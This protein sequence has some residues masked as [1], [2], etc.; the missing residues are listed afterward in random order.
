MDE[1]VINKY[2]KAGEISKKVK[3]LAREIIKPNV[4]ALDVAEK[5]ESEIIRLGGKP[6]WP[7]NLSINEIAAHWTPKINDETVFQKGDLVKVDVGVHVDGF[8][9]DTAITLEVGDNKWKDLINASKEALNAA[10][11]IAKPGVEI[12]KIGAAIEDAIKSMGFTPIANLTGH[13]LDEY[14]NH[15]P[16]SIP[17]FDNKS[18]QKLEEGM[19]IAIEPFATNGVGRVIDAFKSDIYMLENPKPTRSM[20][21]RKILKVVEEDYK[22]LPFGSRWLAKRI[23]FGLNMGLMELTRQEILHNFSVLKEESN[24]M[25]SQHEHT[26]LLLDTP[27]VTTR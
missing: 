25:V 18:T 22:T 3:A 4:K 11:D 12:S 9:A 16:P 23:K 15:T 8:I 27:I 17:N 14:E 10:I 2:K 6:A 26:I 13:G 5:L 24:G 21:G 1:E 7:M 20:I 19:A